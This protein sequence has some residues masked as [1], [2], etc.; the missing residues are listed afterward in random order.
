MF[1][2]QSPLV[3]SLEA[4]S[5][6]PIRIVSSCAQA[7]SCKLA[8][9]NRANRII[10]FVWPQKRPNCYRASRNRSGQKPECVS[11]KPAY[12]FLGVDCASSLGKSA[13]RTPRT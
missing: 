9:T 5:R 12:A 3:A 8:T 10:V 6:I 4:Q 1:P 13:C 2:S 11:K 7:Q